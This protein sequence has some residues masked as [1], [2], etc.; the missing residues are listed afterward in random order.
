MVEVE[1]W[2][3]TFGVTVAQL[4]VAIAKVANGTEKVRQFLGK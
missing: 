2:T 1:Y 4:R 3:K